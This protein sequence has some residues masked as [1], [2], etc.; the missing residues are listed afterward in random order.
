MVY[1]TMVRLVL[2]RVADLSLAENPTL[3]SVGGL[4]IQR[5]PRGSEHMLVWNAFIVSTQLNVLR[6]PAKLSRNGFSPNQAR[7]S[8]DFS[9]W[10][11]PISIIFFLNC[12][13]WTGHYCEL[14]DFRSDAPSLRNS[15]MTKN[16]NFF[17]FKLISEIFLVVRFPFS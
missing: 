9:P 6:V 13:L 5:T 15:Q 11:W 12:S 4:Q 17:F 8:K 2:D 14:G 10:S 1:G 7:G 16:L 3:T